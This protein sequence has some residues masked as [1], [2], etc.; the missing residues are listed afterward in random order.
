MEITNKFKID[1]AGHMED[2]SIRHSDIPIDLSKDLDEAIKMLLWYVPN[3]SSEQAKHNDLLLN[4]AYDDYI[5]TDIMMSMDLR[6][7]DVLICD[8]IKSNLVKYFRGM[9]RVDE[10]KLIMTLADNDETKTMAL[11]RH[12]RNAIAH[13]NFNV[14]NDLVAEAWKEWLKLQ[15]TVVKTICHISEFV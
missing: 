3:I 5:F 2:F 10:Q 6:D 8:E 9:V 15:N 1:A 12:I 13:G 14:I 11:L 7:E 4:P